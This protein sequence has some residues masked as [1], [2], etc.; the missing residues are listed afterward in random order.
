MPTLRDL[1]IEFA[2]AIFSDN[3]DDV[4]FMQ[5]LVGSKMGPDRQLDVYRNNV[6]G[7]LTD[8]LKM[9][10]PVVL[11]LVGVEFFEHLASEFI[12]KTPSKSGNLHNFGGELPEFIAEFPEVIGLIY[13]PDVARL[14]WACHEVFFSED[15]FPLQSDRLA[16][17]PEDQQERLKFHLHPAT[18]LLDFKF[19]IHRI[20]ETNQEDFTGNPA[21]NLDRGGVHLLVRRRDYQ[22][23]LQ[24]LTPG[25]WSFLNSCQSREDLTRAC[26]SAQEIDP[27]FNI[28]E[29][30]KQCVADAILVDF[31]F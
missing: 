16:V 23:V 12:R 29:T 3:E 5:N 28:G 25:E 11:K 31:S 24:P 4:S 27:H 20:W 2:T 15:H 21:I 1:Q 13:L 26:Q 9:A 8:A 10:Y 30:L 6:F 14:E 7:C 17:V 22:A 19:P 18:R